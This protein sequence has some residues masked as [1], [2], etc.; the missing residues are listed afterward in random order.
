MLIIVWSSL[1]IV[2][3]MPQNVV[4]VFL[5]LSIIVRSLPQKAIDAVDAVS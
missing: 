5:R 4:D 2:K 3:S 1:T